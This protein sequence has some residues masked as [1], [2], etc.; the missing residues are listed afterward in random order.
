MDELIFKL[1]ETN[2]ETADKDAVLSD[3][4][5]LLEHP[6]SCNL[7]LQ[8][9]M[10][11]KLTNSFETIYDEGNAWI[12]VKKMYLNVGNNKRA[13]FTI[14][15]SDNYTKQSRY[16]Y[17]SLRSNLNGKISTLVIQQPPCNFKIETEV[18]EI[19]FSE[20]NDEKTI[21]VDVYGA[22]KIPLISKKYIDII[23]DGE[24]YDYDNSLFFNIK[25]DTS[26]KDT[27]EKSTYILTVKF[28]GD[29]NDIKEYYY[30]FPIIHHND[31]ETKQV[32]K[33]NVNA[34][35]KENN[36]GLLNVITN[37]FNKQNK[38]LEFTIKKRNEKNL[39]DGFEIVETKPIIKDKP[40]ELPK[41]A[42]ISDIKIDKQRISLRT[43]TYSQNG[44]V[45]HNSMVFTQSR[46]V[47][48]H[49]NEQYDEQ[50][51]LHLIDVACGN[52][53]WGIE[54]QTYVIVQNAESTDNNVKKVF[55][56]S[57]STNNIVTIREKN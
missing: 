37:E 30:D 45:E 51:E 40:K 21:K 28:L 43:N 25:K 14:Y 35:P 53:F 57:Q 36:E 12:T 8:I 48:C 27:R 52:N 26:I 15:I 47:W 42:S 54:R 3:N 24:I 50:K 4:V 23:A 11:D 19:T 16:Y 34:T 20:K 31:V 2:P 9:L 41:I 39:Y 38:D 1:L 49:V 6:F 33:I 5:L 32:L 46:A 18:D 7:Q 55:V 13:N 10:N 29:F 44:I 22:T 56:V 17:L